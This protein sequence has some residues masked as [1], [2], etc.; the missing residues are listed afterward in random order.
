V[1]FVLRL[2]RWMYTDATKTTQAP[3]GSGPILI[4]VSVCGTKLFGPRMRQSC[5]QCEI[6]GARAGTQTA[7]RKG[8]ASDAMAVFAQRDSRGGHITKGIK[9]IGCGSSCLS[10]RPWPWDSLAL[11]PPA[12]AASALLLL[13]LWFGGHFPVTDR[14]IRASAP[15]RK[16]GPA[17]QYSGCRCP[18]H[19]S[20]PSLPLRRAMK[21]LH[22]LAAN[23]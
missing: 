8:K 9:L 10:A 22:D 11:L 21:S 3:A 14:K 17:K 23:P 16:D 12:T 15:R 4:A 1:R 7:E 5:T 20:A 19:G 13:P 18:G 6:G 2:P